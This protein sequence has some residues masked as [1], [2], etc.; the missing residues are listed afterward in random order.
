MNCIARLSKEEFNNIFNEERKNITDNEKNREKRP[1][2]NLFIEGM[3]HN[4]L[5]KIAGSLSRQGILGNDLIA[6]LIA[7]NLRMC[8]PPLPNSEVISIAKSISEYKNYEQNTEYLDSNMDCK[9]KIKIIL[10]SKRISVNEKSEKITKF[11]INDLNKNG[12]FIYTDTENCF[13]FDKNRK[14][15]VPINLEDNLYK[16]LIHSY[17]INPNIQHYR[18]I[19]EELKIYAFNNGTEAAVYK[20]AHYNKENNC[21]YLK[22]SRNKLYKITIDNIV[23]LDNGTDGILF[24]NVVEVNEFTYIEELEEDTNPIE[25][26]TSICNFDDTVLPKKVQSTLAAACFVGYCM[27]EFLETKPILA[28][29]GTKGSGKTALFKAILKVLFGSKSNVNAMPEKLS[30]IDALMSVSH[31]LLLDN[32]DTHKEGINDKFAVY[33]TG[34]NVRT[35]KLYTNSEVHTIKL[36]AFLGF[37]TRTLSIK[38]DDILQRLILLKV[39]PIENGYI[40]ESKLFEPILKNRN[41]ILSY[42][43]KEVQRILRLI[44]DKAY[45]D[46]RFSFRMADFARFYTLYLDNREKANENLNKLIK[47]QQQTCIENDCIIMYLAEFMRKNPEGYYIAQAIYK[48]IESMISA[49]RNNHQV[50]KNEFFQNYENVFSFAKRLNNISKEI[51]DFIIIETRK[52]RANQ[53]EYKLSK[54]EKFEDIDRVIEIEADELTSSIL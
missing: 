28:I 31:L 40:P 41:K 1:T 25:E 8:K 29:I 53:T 26:I 13:Y 43:I 11:L 20:F 10:N 5:V 33:A 38:R 32:F 34:G 19:F 27:P 3:R 30:D 4:S 54:G 17:S 39:K 16:R 46:D 36:D 18:Y 49:A 24:S 48:S 6:E 45:E 2:A 47:F 35:R 50:N 23:L 14:I 44:S 22:C 15:I 37:T 7:I 12:Y 42:L 21:V 51:S 52:G 9:K